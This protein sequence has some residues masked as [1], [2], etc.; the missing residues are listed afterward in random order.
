MARRP[1]LPEAL[2][3]RIDD[4]LARSGTAFRSGDMT[5]ALALAQEAWDLIPHELY[6]DGLRS[7]LTL[8]CEFDLARAPVLTIENIHVL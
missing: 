5:T 1:Q 6:F 3:T 2:R 4:I 7:D 8:S